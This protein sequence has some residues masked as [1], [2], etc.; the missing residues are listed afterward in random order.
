MNSIYQEL[1]GVLKG[2]ISQYQ[3]YEQVINFEPI[4]P[5]S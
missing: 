2:S 1:A 3:Y 5:I 4:D